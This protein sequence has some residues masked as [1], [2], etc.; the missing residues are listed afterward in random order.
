[1][2]D[3][4]ARQ[5]NLLRDPLFTVRTDGTTTQVSLPEALTLLGSDDDLTFTRL[6]PHQEQAW[7]CFLVQVAVMVAQEQGA[8]PTDAAGWRHGLLALSEGSEDA[9]HLVVTDPAR[10][11]FLQ[12]PTPPGVPVPGKK[13]ER[14]DL[15][16]FPTTPKNHD[17]KSARSDARVPELWVYALLSVQ[18]LDGY[19]G[20]RK[21]GIGRM[22]SG[23]GTRVMAGL[24]RSRR[25]APRWRED[26]ELLCQ[27]QPSPTGGTR[28]LWLPPWDGT[29]SLTVDAMHPLAIEICRR[30]RLHGRDEVCFACDAQTK[31][32]RLDAADRFGD[33]GDP[34]IPLRTKD[35]KALG[36]S[37]NGW[38]IQTLLDL[39]VGGASI[40]QPLCGD[41]LH[42][43]SAT[44]FHVEATA[45]GQGKTNGHH[46]VWIEIP[47]TG[48]GSIFSMPSERDRIAGLGRE[49]LED[50]SATIRTLKYAVM[51]FH[52]AGEK[53]GDDDM[54]AWYRPLQGRADAMFFPHLWRLAAGEPRQAWRDALVREA[55]DLLHKAQR[56]VPVA[57]SRRFRALSASDGAFYAGLRKDNLL[58]PKEA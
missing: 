2:T 53:P 9:W 25:F 38:R 10:P 56:E 52:S 45:G 17:V 30:V 31:V 20:P 12:A 37:E 35:G 48:V 44:W 26:V 51:L 39:V 16:D 15:L 29:Q 6:R 46:S 42:K 32:P 4:L 47:S 3:A 34:W 33:L 14:P 8:I 54:G 27:Q 41:P 58:P 22:N 55:T 11:A 13:I 19:A 21:W 24:Y 23:N 50:V 49:M 36:A 40:K 18:T 43:P 1:V 5:H 28:L 57:S 7:F